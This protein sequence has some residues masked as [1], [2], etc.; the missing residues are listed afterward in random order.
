MKKVFLILLIILSISACNQ[1]NTNEEKSVSNKQMTEVNTAE[2]RL[3]LVSG[4]FI[5]VDTAAVIKGGSKIYG[6][7]LDSMGNKLNQKSKALQQE[8]YEMINVKVKAHI[9]Q[10]DKENQWEEFV[11][12]KEI[13]SV[14]R[15]Q[16]NKPKKISI[17]N[18]K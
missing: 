7:V 5:T 1:S 4:D 15:P 13:L 6:V 10:N 11:E 2:D 14:E 12:I 17:S 8:P 16:N 9:I 3:T 18:N